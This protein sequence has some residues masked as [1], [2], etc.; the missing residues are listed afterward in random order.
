M[1]VSLFIVPPLTLKFTRC[2]EPSAV[3]SHL[4]PG[5]SQALTLKKP[6]DSAYVQAERK[7]LK[8]QSSV[9]KAPYKYYR[10]A[11]EIVMI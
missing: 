9:C 7:T 10:F 8:E 6:W 1:F 3:S 11:V 5:Q 4:Q 2:Y